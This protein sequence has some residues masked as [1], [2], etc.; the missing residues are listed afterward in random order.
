MRMNI[1]FYSVVAACE[2]KT[3]YTTEYFVCLLMTKTNIGFLDNV[4]QM[5]HKFCFL[6]I[7][8]I[9]YICRFLDTFCYRYLIS[10]NQAL[11]AYCVMIQ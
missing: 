5:V 1:T 10:K 9:N 8:G 2:Y 3:I 4:L 11:H 7:L 6:N